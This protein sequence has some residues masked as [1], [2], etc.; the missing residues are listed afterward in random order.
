MLVVVLGSLFSVLLGGS[1]L[2][3]VGLCLLI[4]GGLVVG[5]LGV[6]VVVFGFWY[7]FGWVV[8]GMVII[9]FGMGLVILVVFIVIFNNVLV[10]CVGMVLLV[11]EVFYEF[12]GLLVVVMLGSLSVV[13]YSV[14]LLVLV[15]MFV[16]VC[17]GF[18]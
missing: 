10:Y 3:W 18:I 4:C 6:G 8:V 14:F 5:V 7:G 1:I 12:G 2:Y 9:G 17:E 11:E 15:D 13:M 16:F